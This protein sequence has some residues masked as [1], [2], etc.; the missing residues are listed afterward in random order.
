M[1]K[2][3]ILLAIGI[4]AFSGCKNKSKKNDNNSNGYKITST[5]QSEPQQGTRI[6]LLANTDLSRKVD[7]T[8]DISYMS[9]QE[10]R[11]LH[12]LVYAVHG[13]YF[14][15]SDIG[16]F[17]KVNTTWY[18]ELV[19][20][21]LRE[22]RLPM[23]YEDVS[24]SA[25]EQSFVDRI[26]ARM[27]ELVKS[28]YKY[29]GADDLGN[30]D[31][32]VNLFHYK[33]VD[34][35][36]AKKLVDYNFAITRGNHQ[37]LFHVYEQNDYNLTPSFITTDLYLQAFH[38]YFGYTLK[39]LEQKKFIPIL[40]ELCYEL[41]SYSTE[42]SITEDQE[43]KKLAEYNA[44][45]YAI[46]YYILTGEE[47][48]I[49]VQHRGHYKEEID[50]INKAEDGS[51]EFLSADVFHYSLFIPRG[52]YTRKDEMK[53]YF[54]AMMW[55]Q[56]APFCREESEQLKQVVFSSYMLKSGKTKDERTLLSLYNSIY[57]PIVFLVG[58]PDNLSFMDIVDFMTKENLSDL[59]TA[60]HF[61]TLNRI[62]H[63]LAELAKNRNQ[64]TPKIEL[65]C[66][67]KINF[68]PQ[69]YLI[70]NDVMQNLVDVGKDAKRAYPKG[71]DVFA[72][73]GS[74]SADDL[75]THFYKEKSS[76]KEYPNEMAKMKRKFKN[77]K[78]WNG[79]VYNKWIESLLALQKKDKN[80]PLF[81]QT[82]A[83]GY[84][85][86]NT[87]L[88]SWAELKHDAILY[89]EQPMAAEC[90]GGDELE[91][92]TVGYVEPNLKFWNKLAELIDLTKI[93]LQ[94]NDLLTGDLEGKTNQLED[95]VKF[96][97]QVTNKELAKEKLTNE[98]YSTIRYM[99]SSLEYF[100]LSVIDP[101]LYLDN[102]SLVQG[103]DKSVAV[104]ADIYTR[105]VPG[106][107]KNGILHVATGNVNNIYVV[108]EIE[109]LLYLTKGATLSYYEFVEPLGTR[110]TD[111]EWQE[112]LEKGQAP[113]VQKWMEDLIIGEEP[114]TD[115]RIFY[116]SGC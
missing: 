34:S 46:P 91:I 113:P 51:S 23:N 44:A 87:S 84:K 17:L 35:L 78:G 96:L 27:N 58:L 29:N 89:G 22:R 33:D 21:L 55:L 71:L 19:Y 92:V 90:G 38:M 64:I 74:E 37:Q 5:E 14:E 98:E 103:P 116:S 50:K 18:E 54:K 101:D 45:Y 9:L 85:N 28:N 109:G 62:N 43:I 115:E 105:N 63:M 106:C 10:L 94:N 66:P 93:M 4:M 42:L 52:H 15:Q 59:N 72:A 76:W 88:A 110:L 53:A 68:M 65:T 114:K 7:L 36:F 31:N 112:R 99:G 48:E 73:F 26:E 24:L 57:E 56:I 95:Y 39:S 30:V 25:E 13:M 80:Y 2:V 79:S 102:W 77:Y 32:I 40:S 3:T 11:L 70:D 100:T 97:I 67:D 61:Q 1:K 69:R 82:E 60:L 107:S 20:E 104:V 12:S 75:L 83:W 86:L 8:Q 47:L 16:S 81:M 111:E 41:Y 108:V 6:D 49:P